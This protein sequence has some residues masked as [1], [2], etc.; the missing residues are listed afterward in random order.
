MVLV[1]RVLYS[2]T[3]VVPSVFN[4]SLQ[5]LFFVNNGNTGADLTAFV[6]SAAGM[7]DGGTGELSGN[8]HAAFFSGSAGNTQFDNIVSFCAPLVFKGKT[9]RTEVSIVRLTI[10]ASAAANIEIVKNPVLGGTASWTSIGPDIVLVSDQASTTVVGGELAWAERAEKQDRF[11]IE[12]EPSGFK[13]IVTIFPGEVVT[14]AAQADSGT[15]NITVAVNWI[16]PV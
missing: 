1:H 12:P 15:S 2:N 13:Q 8:R 7:I 3:S 6:G 4:P 11:A 14:I 16:E 10:T 5:F 9:N